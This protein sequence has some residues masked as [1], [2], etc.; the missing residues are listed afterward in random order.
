MKSRQDC[1]SNT[2]EG[3]NGESN[4]DSE[5]LLMMNILKT[6]QTYRMPASGRLNSV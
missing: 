4:Y 6:F 3:A 1:Y 2:K 5:N